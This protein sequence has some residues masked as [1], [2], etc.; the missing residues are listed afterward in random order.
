MCRQGR[1]RTGDRAGVR[2]G[3]TSEAR[4]RG[5]AI[6][7]APGLESAYA[8]ALRRNPRHGGR[9][10]HAF[11]ARLQALA[12]RVGGALSRAEALA[13]AE[14]GLRQSPGCN[15]GLAGLAPRRAAAAASR[16]AR[17]PARA[18]HREGAGVEARGRRLALLPGRPTPARAQSRPAPGA[19]ALRAASLPLPAGDL[20]ALLP[21]FGVPRRGAGAL[22]PPEAGTVF[23]IR[24][25]VG[26][27]N[28]YEGFLS[29]VAFIDGQRVCV[30][31]FSYVDGAL[32]GAPAGATL[33]VTRKQSG[34]HPEHLRA[35]ARCFKHTSPPYFCL[36]ALAGIARAIGAAEIAA[37]RA[38]AH[39]HFSRGHAEVLQKKPMTSSGSTSA[40]AK[41]TRTRTASPYR[42]RP[43]T[44][45]RSPPRIASVRAGG[46]RIAWP[47][48]RAPARRFVGP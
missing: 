9:G 40:P 12:A 42:S 47:W 19:P 41:S 48:R 4:R 44:R 46:A 5:L 20:R 32:F 29:A 34:R 11:V 26:T 35:F 33:F 7:P 18:R 37:I 14:P 10:T 43:A 36:A 45:C 27:D 6:R 1:W 39:P 17:G 22:A 3:V 23:D 16:R 25:M 21:R 24:L 30:M 13:V 8:R 31:S 15:D 2:S 28:L 38:R